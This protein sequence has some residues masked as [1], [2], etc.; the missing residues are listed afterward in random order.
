MAFFVISD[1]HGSAADLQTVLTKYQQ[2]T[3][4]G[5]LLLG[6]FLSHGPRNPL[7][8]GY[9]PL[10]C[11]DLLTSFAH[12]II[13]VAGNCDAHVDHSNLPF[14]M[15]QEN[16]FFWQGRKVMLHHGHLYSSHE[17]LRPG[18]IFLSGHTHIPLAENRNEI[19]YGNPGSISLPKGGYAKSYAILS[20]EFIVYDL[21]DNIIKRIAL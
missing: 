13:A 19:I 5:L 7:P 21:A 11:I 15:P 10:D 3:Y 16:V 17:A 2:G 1:I 4:E 20:D 6:D 9:G 14:A 12:D 18:D 8:N